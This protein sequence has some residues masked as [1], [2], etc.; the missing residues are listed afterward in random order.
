[1]LRS[2][3]VTRE[4]TVSTDLAAAAALV[5]ADGVQLQQVLLN[6]IINAADAMSDLPRSGAPCSPSAP[7]A[8]RAK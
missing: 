3:L 5:D 8:R 1:M 7:S 2:E 4:I 6:L